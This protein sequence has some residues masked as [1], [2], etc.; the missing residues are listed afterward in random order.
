MKMFRTVLPV[1][2]VALL[3]TAFVAVHETPRISPIDEANIVSISEFGM[4]EDPISKTSKMHKGI[5]FIAEQGT[6][7]RA[8]AGGTILEANTAE[9]NYG[10][11]VRIQHPHGY[12][13][14]YAH[15]DKLAVKVG[16][17]VGVGQQIGTV[18]NTG[19]STVPHLHYEVLK[20]GK[21]LNPR[22]FFDL[23]NF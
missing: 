17:A 14:F 18:G 12:V 6:P 15:M 2:S 8:T 22:K 10:N 21:N 3:F 11:F 19:L 13:T 4:R 1:L 23:K 20:D 16:E 9:S 5:D 7:I